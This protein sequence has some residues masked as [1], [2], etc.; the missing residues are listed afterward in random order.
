MTIADIAASGLKACIQSFFP[1]L[2]DDDDDAASLHNDDAQL[3]QPF[4]VIPILITYCL[5][6]HG[7]I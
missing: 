2:A 7:I 5:W 1:P 4:W 6:L 3:C